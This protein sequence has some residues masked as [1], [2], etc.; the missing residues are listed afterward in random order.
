M[1]GCGSRW[2]RDDGWRS[3]HV[4]VSLSHDDGTNGYGAGRHDRE[5]PKRQ[6]KQEQY[7]TLS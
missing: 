1:G 6:E 5:D 3:G 4:V 7:Q 2:A